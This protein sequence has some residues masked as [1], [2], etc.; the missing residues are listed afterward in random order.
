MVTQK[1]VLVGESYPFVSQF[2]VQ[3]TLLCLID[4][5]TILKH[6]SGDEVANLCQVNQN[7]FLIGELLYALSIWP[8]GL[9]NGKAN[10][11]HYFY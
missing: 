2:V 11:K 10:L 4:D 8:L 6:L 5:C 3:I 1:V 9:F 7:S